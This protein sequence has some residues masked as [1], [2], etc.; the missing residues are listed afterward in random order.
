MDEEQPSADRQPP[1]LPCTVYLYHKQ[2]CA[3]R[4]ILFVLLA[5]GTLPEACCQ[6]KSLSPLNGSVVELA[7]QPE[8][9]AMADSW[10]LTAAQAAALGRPE[11]AGKMRICITSYTPHVYCDANQ[12]QDTY[13]GYQVR[14]M[15]WHSLV[16]VLW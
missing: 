15:R 3:V 13:T 9:Q 4:T 10:R 16:P 1:K 14:S 12:P 11:V 7:T 5:L 6:N 2:H 8:L